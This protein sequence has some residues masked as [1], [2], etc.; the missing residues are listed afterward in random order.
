MTPFP[1]EQAGSGRLLRYGSSPAKK[2]AALR[3]PPG[4][5]EED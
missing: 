5:K 3:I 2:L 1:R 4:A